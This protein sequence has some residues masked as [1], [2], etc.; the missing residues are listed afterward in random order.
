M[1]ASG[2]A[3]LLSTVE[4]DLSSLE[5]WIKTEVQDIAVAAWADIKTLFLAM[6]A[7][8][9]TIF[10]GLVAEAQ[11]DEKSGIGVEA[12]LADVLTLA[13]QKELAWVASL[14]GQV[15]VSATALASQQV[16]VPPAAS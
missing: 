1:S 3:T 14:P 4:A 10:K 16:Y 8:Q 5:G 7:E 11:A 13:E 6:T 15:L 9:Y 12:T 2:S